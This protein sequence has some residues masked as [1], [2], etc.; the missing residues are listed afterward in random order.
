MNQRAITFH[1]V[2]LFCLAS[3]QVGAEIIKCVQDDGTIIY[4]DRQSA[5]CATKEI[6]KPPPVVDPTQA[7]RS[8]QERQ[9][10]LDEISEARK[11]R[12]EEETK[13][14]EEAGIK[15]RNCELA[16][17]KLARVNAN[18]RVYGTDEA[19]NRVKLGEEDRLERLAA[20]QKD[21]ETWCN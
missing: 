17:D 11:K 8:L 14:A 3:T 20:A 6:L 2:V 10:V 4:T 19:G 16:R 9:K 5:S 13:L 1:A 7:E 18:P 15:Q 21:I 12:Q